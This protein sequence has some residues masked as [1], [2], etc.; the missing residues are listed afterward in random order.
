MKCICKLFN[1]IKEE[2]DIQIHKSI[3]FTTPSTQQNI[4]KEAKKK[5]DVT[6]YQETN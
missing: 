1:S 2:Y 3:T 5:E 6:H 4:S